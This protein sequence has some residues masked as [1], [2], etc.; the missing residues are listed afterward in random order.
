MSYIFNGWP[1]VNYDLE[2]NGK[3]ITI[4]NLTL[5]FKIAT[6]LQNKAAVIY[7]Y[8]VVNGERADIIAHKYYGDTTLDWLIYTI[9][10]IIDPQFEWPLDDPSFDRFIREKYGSPESAKQTHHQYQKLLRDESVLF[11]GTI[12]DK[13]WVTVDLETYNLTSPTLRRQVDKYTYEL[14]LREKRSEI[15]LLDKRYLPNILNSYREVVE[16]LSDES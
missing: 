9:N 14:E 1:T 12:I 10:N 16:S 6:L 3:P 15:K 8:N 7:K 4:T 2:K 5:R 13:K 11:D